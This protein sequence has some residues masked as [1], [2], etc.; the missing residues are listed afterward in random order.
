MHPQVATWLNLVVGV[1]TLVGLKSVVDSVIHQLGFRYFIYR[2]HFPGLPNGAYQIQ[3]D[4]APAAWHTYRQRPEIG[5]TWDP[6]HVRALRAVTP[7]LWSRVKSLHPDHFEKA[8]E[9]GLAT[10][11]TQPMHGPRGD[12]SS[13]SFIKD[14]A[15]LRSERDVLAALPQCQLFTSFAHDAVARIIARRLDASIAAEDRPG[16]ACRLS[17]RENECLGLAALGKTIQQIAGILPISE[18]TVAFHLVNARRKL[19]T[20]SLRHAV[21][22]A[23]SLGLIRAA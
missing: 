3:L 18:R 8:R 5:S 2:G 4:T 1:T 14:R 15:G 17:M 19:Q 11:V 21:T 16:A 23:A 10:G 22:K 6:L 12:W 20:G 13:I 7:I 9:L